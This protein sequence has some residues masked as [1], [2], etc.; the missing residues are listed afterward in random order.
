MFSV[1]MF[2]R[3]SKPLPPMPIPAMFNL[4]EGAIFPTLLPRTRLGTSVKTTVAAAV[5]SKNSR[6]DITSLFIIYEI[7][8]QMYSFIDIYPLN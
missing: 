6:L 5:F 1:A 2:L 4:S 7:E 8:Y 3:T